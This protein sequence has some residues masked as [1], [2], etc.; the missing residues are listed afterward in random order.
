MSLLREKKKKQLADAMSKAGV[1]KGVAGAISNETKDKVRKVANDLGKGIAE[2]VGNLSN[3]RTGGLASKVQRLKDAEK[4]AITQGVRDVNLNTANDARD[5]TTE[6]TIGKRFKD[7]SPI[8][9]KGDFSSYSK[10]NNTPNRLTPNDNTQK[11]NVK[12]NLSREE[13]IAAMEKG[14][15]E[16]NKIKNRKKK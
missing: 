14:I 3:A 2:R 10:Y 5:A 11:S 9:G 15:R 13:K 16:A 7:I 8:T 4:A 12:S 1:G 6:K